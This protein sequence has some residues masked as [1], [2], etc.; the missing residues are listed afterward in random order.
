MNN[1][2]LP[3]KDSATFRGLITALQAL[4]TFIIGL[5]L[6][7]WQVPG[8]PKAFLDFVWNNAPSL[9]FTLG[10][11]SSIGV[12]IISFLSNYFFRKGTVPTY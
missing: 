2:R 10:I 8:V 6:A 9:L 4:V 1:L 11:S 12:G 7:I 5:I 3:Q